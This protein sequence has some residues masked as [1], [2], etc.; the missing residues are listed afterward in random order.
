MAICLGHFLP[1]YSLAYVLVFPDQHP[2]AGQQ[3]PFMAN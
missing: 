1:N 2:N 3:V